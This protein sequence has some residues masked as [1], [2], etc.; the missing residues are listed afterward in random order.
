MHK[1]HQ[2][3]NF[4]VGAMLGSALGALTAMVFTTKKGHKIKQNL[5]NQYHEF[6]GKVKKSAN[7]NKRKA[8]RVVSRIAKNIEKKLKQI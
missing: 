2:G 5:L 1:G 8:K 4:F 3:R 6:E 7:K